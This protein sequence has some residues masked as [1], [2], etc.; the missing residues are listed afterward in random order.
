MSYKHFFMLVFLTS[1][2]AYSF[3]VRE[4]NEFKIKKGWFLSSQ[5][6][7]FSSLSGF[8]DPQIQANSFVIREKRTLSSLAPQVGILLGYDINDFISVGL[9]LE[10]GYVAG[11]ARIPDDPESPT[12]YSLA[13]VDFI[14]QGQWNFYQRFSLIGILGIGGA[15]MTP[16][17][18]EQSNRL[19][20]NICGGFGLRYDTLLNGLFVGFNLNSNWSL[21]SGTGIDQIPGIISFSLI[22]K[23]GYVF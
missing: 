8:S 4:V 1:T 6:G 19:G 17:A 5:V 21:I 2:L 7:F 11:A 18:S 12:H 20:A 23:I 16:R 13:F 9:K 15:F 22:P 3:N 14:L 10:Q